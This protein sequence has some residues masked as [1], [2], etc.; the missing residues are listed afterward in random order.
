MDGAANTQPQDG[1]K[2]L[3]IRSLFYSF[4]IISV[5]CTCK[6][7]NGINVHQQHHLLEKQNKI[8]ECEELLEEEKMS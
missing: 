1:Q 3:R 5:I 4:L 8:S 7:E 2:R 6:D